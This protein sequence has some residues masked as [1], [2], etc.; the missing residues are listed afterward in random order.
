MSSPMTRDAL[1]GSLR[2]LYPPRTSTV[3]AAPLSLPGFRSE[4]EAGVKLRQPTK[5]NSSTC[6]QRTKV[7]TSSQTYEDIFSDAGRATPPIVAGIAALTSSGMISSP[8]RRRI[9]RAKPT[10][11]F[12]FAS[13][14]R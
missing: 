14:G 10:I 3:K 7:L 2:Y 6:S 9:W 1:G 11:T 5:P 8:K 4:E 13:W 12:S